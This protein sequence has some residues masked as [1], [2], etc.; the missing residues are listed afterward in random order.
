ML[1][2]FIQSWPFTFSPFSSLY[3]KFFKS[4][5][6]IFYFETEK[7]KSTNIDVS[8][9]KNTFKPPGKMVIEYFTTL[10]VQEMDEVIKICQDKVY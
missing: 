7:I 2:Y 1:H 6:Q 10:Y 3:Y 8:S 9:I 5:L 4:I